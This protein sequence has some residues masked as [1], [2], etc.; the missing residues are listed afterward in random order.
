MDL[1]RE[2]LAYSWLVRD[3]GAENGLRLSNFAVL[4]PS[5][6]KYAKKK[7]SKIQVEKGSEKDTIQEIKMIT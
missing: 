4:V 7:K 5:R 3:L 6:P 1:R 2:K